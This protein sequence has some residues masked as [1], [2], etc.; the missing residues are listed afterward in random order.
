M[1]SQPREAPVLVCITN[2][3]DQSERGI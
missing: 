2:E 3:L 1:C